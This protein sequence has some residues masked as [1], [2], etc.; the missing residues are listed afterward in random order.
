MTSVRFLGL[1]LFIIS[2]LVSLGCGKSFNSDA[3]SARGNIKV[4]IIAPGSVND[5][6]AQ[7]PYSLTTVDLQKVH[8]LVSVSGRYARFYTQASRDGDKLKGIQPHGQF[9]KRK[10]GVFVPK[11]F[12][13]LQLAT[14]Y[15]HAQNLVQIENSLS[16]NSNQAQT[17]SSSI[18]PRPDPSLSSMRIQPLKIVLNTPVLNTRQSENNAIYDADLDAII[19]FKYS[20]G[21]LPLS[22]NGG[23]FAHE[24]F[25]SIFSRLVLKKLRDIDVFNVPAQLHSANDVSH[26]L[27]T[28]EILDP[29]AHLGKVMSKMAADATKLR[30]EEEKWYYSLILKG[31]NE[32]LA[33]YWGWSYVKDVSF[34]T[35]SIRATPTPRQLDLKSQKM[36]SLS[37]FSMEQMRSIIS[38]VMESKKEK[39]ELINGFS[40]QL[41]SRVA[42]FFKSYQELIQNERALSPEAAQ[43]LMNQMVIDFIQNLATTLPQSAAQTAAQKSDTDTTSSVVTTYYLLKQYFAEV[44][45]Q[46]EKECLFL[47]EFLEMDSQLKNKMECTSPAANSFKLGTKGAQ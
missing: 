34:I 20:D 44:P 16:I 15:Y 24:Y 25:H 30:A 42:L 22:L 39:L 35:H 41:G 45:T 31:F 1:W 12:L 14:L 19:Y 13:S 23:V 5:D 32:G 18:E 6:A 38:Q 8:D 37:L 9:L 17:Q 47:K 33:D 28:Q 29:N 10:D 3:Q 36:E 26:S 11:N 7:L 43:K 2:S 46:T 40:Y 21:Q 4:Q 27:S